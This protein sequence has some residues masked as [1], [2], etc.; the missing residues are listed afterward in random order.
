M[1]HAEEPDGVGVFV[2][3]G[4]AVEEEPR[5]LVEVAL[6]CFAVVNS[7]DDLR[8]GELEREGMALM[9][10]GRDRFVEEELN[11]CRNQPGRRVE[12]SERRD[13]ECDD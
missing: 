13:I 10:W 12:M 1:L 6:P 8:L 4:I 5:C 2:G 11:G 3:G 9:R 7:A